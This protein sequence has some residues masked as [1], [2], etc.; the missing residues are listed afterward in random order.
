MIDLETL[1]TTPTAAIIEIGAV[2]FDID[3]GHISPLKE[4]S[5]FHRLIEFDS[6]C[7][8]RDI[9]PNTVRWWFGQPQEARERFTQSIGDPV[10]NVISAFYHWCE[11]IIS[12]EHQVCVWGNG[13]TFDISIVENIL[14]QYG[15]DIPWKFYN[16]RDVRTIVHLADGI[17]DKN[18]FEFEGVRHNALDDA[19]H[20]VKYVSAMWQLFRP[21]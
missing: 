2:E 17:V 5:E 8:N 7:V 14:Q 6:A 19:K 16:I 13:A 3:T 1:S 15:F 21:V 20:Q 12:T 11:R 18:G 4:R 10:E 9:D